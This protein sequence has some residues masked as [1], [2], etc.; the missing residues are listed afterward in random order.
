MGSLHYARFFDEEARDWYNCLGYTV[1]N[2]R[3]FGFEVWYDYDLDILVSRVG[4]FDYT[5]SGS[6]SM[7]LLV[8]FRNQVDPENYGANI[9]IAV[10]RDEHSDWDVLWSKELVQ[11]V[12][13]GNYNSFKKR[14]K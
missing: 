8:N 5:S 9:A 10:A 1:I 7:Q 2:V 11:N 4:D 12:N 13:I 3:F 14:R 6:T